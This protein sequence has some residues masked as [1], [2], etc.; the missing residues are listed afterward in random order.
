MRG[1][2]TM[3]EILMIPVLGTVFLILLPLYLIY[4]VIHHGEE[5]EERQER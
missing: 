1:E 3:G 4:E 2:L 5:E